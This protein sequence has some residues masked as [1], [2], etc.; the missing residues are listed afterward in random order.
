MTRP[1]DFFA[2]SH[3]TIF[4]R[5]ADFIFWAVNEAKPPA[6]LPD[7]A[8]ARTKKHHRATGTERILKKDLEK[9]P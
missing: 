1:L 8:A 2:S 7:K 5:P 4:D 6:R 3:L 9:H